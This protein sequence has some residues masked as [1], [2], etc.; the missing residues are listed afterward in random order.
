MPDIAKYLKVPVDVLLGNMSQ[1]PQNEYTSNRI[2]F[3]ER[4]NPVA[5]QDDIYILENH[6]GICSTNCETTFDNEEIN[7]LHFFRKFNKAGKKK[8]MAYMN[9]ICHNEQYMEDEN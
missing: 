4:G 1:F 7:L 9:D 3:D 2:F 6:E 5:S 8:I